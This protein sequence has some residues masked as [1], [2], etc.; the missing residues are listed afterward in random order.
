MIA[1]MVK[2]TGSTL[3]PE[4]LALYARLAQKPGHVASALGM[5]ANWELDALERDLSHLTTPLVLIVG[6]KDRTIPPWQAP[7]VRSL[8]RSAEIVELPN[9]GHLAHEEQPRMVADLLTNLARD[10]GVLAECAPSDTA[11]S[12]G[13]KRG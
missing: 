1:R 11:K 4:G 9:L 3:E 7:R 10:H 2:N 12:V 13:A 8:V 6:A 5:M